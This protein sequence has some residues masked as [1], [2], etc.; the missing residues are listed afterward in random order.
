MVKRLS[1]GSAC[2][3]FLVQLQVPGKNMPVEDTTVEWSEK[4][5]P[6]LPVARLDIPSQQ[7]EA[8]N[9]ACENL[10]FNPWHSLPDH[11]PIGVMN[12]IR[13]AVYL[14]VSRYRRQS[15]GVPSCEPKDWTTTDPASCESASTPVATQATAAGP[16]SPH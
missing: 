4:D 8:N 15:N 12:R 7:F 13:K 11:R 6:F 16:S 9:D 5:S 14:E 3:D 1:G 2:F 10:A